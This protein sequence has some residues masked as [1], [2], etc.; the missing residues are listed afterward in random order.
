[1]I[2][3]LSYHRVM[4]SISIMARAI[5]VIE[6]NFISPF[7]R[8]FC[9]L[10]ERSAFHITHRHS[11]RHYKW[12]KNEGWCVNA[13]RSKERQGLGRRSRTWKKKQ[14]RG[15]FILTIYSC[16]PCY[17]L[18]SKRTPHCIGNFSWC[19]RFWS[20]GQ[21]LGSTGSFTLS[22][23][24]NYEGQC[25]QILPTLAIPWWG[26]FVIN[27]IVWGW[28]DS[29]IPMRVGVIQFV[30]LRKINKFSK[31]CLSMKF[32]NLHGHRSICK[33]QKI[34][35]SKNSEIAGMHYFINVRCRQGTIILS[36]L[37][38]VNILNFRQKFGWGNTPRFRVGGREL[39]HLSRKLM[40]PDWTF[41]LLGQQF[42]DW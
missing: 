4:F 6:Y 37:E 12:K 31:Q 25:C 27:I 38:I 15:S 34:W 18:P 40:N 14:D 9:N 23:Q 10:N 8:Q 22:H 20:H 21:W 24:T 35:N 42:G 13:K 16:L 29:Q 11:W 41:W 19:S 33:Y 30:F 5:I 7:Q 1:M 28:M 32:W 3:I 26:P 39:L 2:K 36:M 17:G